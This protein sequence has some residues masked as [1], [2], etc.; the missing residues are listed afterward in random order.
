MIV[1]FDTSALVRRYH[2]TEPGA[3][4]VRQLCRRGVA[5]ELVILSLTSI[6]AAS[7][8]NRKLQQGQIDA[9]HRDRMWRL[10][11]V[12]RSTQYRVIRLSEVTER[13]A[14]RLLFQHRLRAYDAA[15]LA[16]AVEFRRTLPRAS[17]FRFCTADRGQALAATAEGL[18]VEFIS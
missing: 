18:T 17:E 14:Q 15:Q 6:E 3:L 1:Y 10:F 12:H 8:F 9:A 13:R 7:A 16:G 11:Q 4:R 2:V 5:D